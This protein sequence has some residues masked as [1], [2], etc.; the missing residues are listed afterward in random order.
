MIKSALYSENIEQHLKERY[1]VERELMVQGTYT[2]KGEKSKSNTRILEELFIEKVLKD[3]YFSIHVCKMIEESDFDL[4]DVFAYVNYIILEKYLNKCD[5]FDASRANGNRTSLN[6]AT[7]EYNNDKKTN[8][9]IDKLSERRSEINDLKYND[10]YDILRS[11]GNKIVLKALESTPLRNEMINIRWQDKSPFC[12]EDGNGLHF[13]KLSSYHNKKNRNNEWNRR[14]YEMEKNDALKHLSFNDLRDQTRFLCKNIKSYLIEYRINERYLKTSLFAFLNFKQEFFCE[15]TD[16]LDKFSMFGNKNYSDSHIVQFL[17]L[18]MDAVFISQLSWFNSLEEGQKIE[19]LNKYYD[20]GNLCLSNLNLFG[21]HGLLHVLAYNEAM[22]LYQNNEYD[23]AIYIANQVLE[24]TGDEFLKYM[25]VSLMAD[26]SQIKNDFNSALEHFKI[27]YD[28]SKSFVHDMKLAYFLNKSRKKLP[29]GRG[30]RVYRTSNDFHIFQFME[31]LNIAEMHCYLK[32]KDKADECFRKLNE[33]IRAFSIPKRIDILYKLATFC[34]RHQDLLKYR[35]YLKVAKLA[36]KYEDYMLDNIEDDM[37]NEIFD[38]L[39]LDVS[40]TKEICVRKWIDNMSSAAIKHRN[41]IVEIPS[42]DDFGGDLIKVYDDYN[43]CLSYNPKHYEKMT[44]ILE[45]TGLTDTILD[46]YSI[47]PVTIEPR[48]VLTRIENAMRDLE[49]SKGNTGVTFHELKYQDI[50]QRSNLA[51]SRCYYALDD[52]DTSEN[53]LKE[54]I[55]NTRDKDVLFNAQYILGMCLIKNGNVPS[56]IIEFEKAVD[57]PEHNGM[58][59]ELCMFELLHIENKEIFYKVLYSI[60]DK[61]NSTPINRDNYHQNGYFLAVWQFNQFGLTDEA[62]HLIEK[63]LS[64]EDNELVRIRLLEEKAYISY[65]D[66]DYEISKSILEEIIDIISRSKQDT[67]EEYSFLYSSAWHKLS[68]ICAKKHEFK[69]AAECINTA[70]DSLKKGKNQS[71]NIEQRIES[72][73]KL[74]KICSILSEHVIMLDKINIKEVIDIFKT[75]DEIIFNGLDQDYN[76]GFD[77]ESACTEYGKGL[78]TYMHD[79][80]SVYLREYVFSINEEP[81]E[82]EFWGGYKCK[83]KRGTITKFDHGLQNVLNTYKKTIGLGQWKPF[84]D[85]VFNL[86]TEFKNNPYIE[87]SCEFIK[88]FMEYEQWDIIVEACA[89][90]SDDRNDAAHYGKGSLDDVLKVRGKIIK[91]INEVIDILETISPSVNQI[92]D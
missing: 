38:L 46:T 1:F 57:M 34:G 74:Q 45:S 7:M 88:K 67:S 14:I 13:E 49:N 31:L 39:E 3:P 27:A 22:E 77:F 24:N 76:T 15:I 26:I 28:I 52:F 56:G 86:K 11:K 21:K 68:L 25:C 12:W 62:M 36:D 90:V 16:T 54:I 82:C 30:Y 29:M 20:A 6:S 41:Q 37:G 89:R 35:L 50:I 23:N 69:T 2:N 85:N 92:T 33:D 87:D 71:G 59:F 32:N 65:F 83:N 81:V 58:I 10:Y 47:V 4:D 5:L 72:Y 42:N 55:A 80:I 64:V 78:E 91:N 8:E 9:L 43:Q 44:S 61:I 75:G 19:I 66:C 48:R 53:I 70:I 51:R 84:I 73:C 18:Y 40:L 63:G 60:V 79:Q 17:K